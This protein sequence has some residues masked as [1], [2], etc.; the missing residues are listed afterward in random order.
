MVKRP[1]FNGIISDIG[2][3]T[4]NMYHMNCQSEEANKVCRRVSCLH[5]KRCK[6]YGTDHKPFIQ[7]LRKVRNLSGVKKVFV[8]SGIR[9]DLASLD[10]ELLK[11]VETCC[12]HMSGADIIGKGPS[13]YE[14]TGSR[15]FHFFCGAI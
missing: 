1:K 12:G 8:N 11:S 10:D 9:Y 6:H 7:L 2:G 4:A 3:P 13:V 15:A 14:K 5:P